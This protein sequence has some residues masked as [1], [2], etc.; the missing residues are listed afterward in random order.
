MTRSSKKIFIVAGE[1]SGDIHGAKLMEALK[2]Q[3]PE[4]QFMGH[5]GDLMKAQGLHLLEHVDTLSMM[6]F[7]EVI[8][9][10]P[11]MTRVMKNTVSAI[12]TERPDRIILI[13]YP[14]FNLRLAKR[15]SKLGIPVTYFIL[16]QVW[17]WK[18]KRV[19]VLRQFVDQ[20]ISIFPFE[21]DWFKKRNLTID[22]VGHPFVERTITHDQVMDFYNRHNLSEE[23]PRLILLPGSRQQEIDRHW[24]IFM[25]TVHE[26][27]LSV[28]E[29]QVILGKAP[30]VELNPIPDFI[31]VETVDIPA[32]IQGSTAAL[33]SSGTVTLEAAVLDTPVAVC[34]KLS[35]MS[36]FLLKRF[37]K[38]PFASMANLIAGQKIVPEYLQNAM[39]PHEIAVELIPLLS[40]TAQR[41][42]MLLGFETIRR[43]LGAPGVYNRAATLIL[44]RL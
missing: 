22:Y 25:Q 39:R 7:S 42:K 5:G 33:A 28:P 4:I 9:H 14:G 23:H 16:P 44:N 11:Y 26:V 43:S 24:P 32:A 21:H 34:Y 3:S 27:R 35:A 18:E 30:G 19:N 20:Y 8:K 31:H 38:V 29:L 1:T 12:E 37:V 13:D 10:L 17:A 36:W 40:Q 6:G 2:Q 15:I 41:K